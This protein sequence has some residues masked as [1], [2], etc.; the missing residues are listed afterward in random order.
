MDKNKVQITAQ[1]AAGATAVTFGSVMRIILKVL[2]TIILIGITTGLLFTCIFAYYVKTNLT[3]DLDISLDDMSLNLASTIYYTDENGE[4]QELSSVYGKENRIWVDYENIPKYMTYAA[5]A[6]EDK[7]FYNHKG[8]DW[9]RTL[10]AFTNMFVK[11]KDDFGGSTITQQLIK[12]LTKEDDITVQRKILEIFRALEFER[13]YNDKDKIMEW[14]LN[15]IYLGQSC[16]GVSTASQTYFGKNVWELDLAE[17]ASIIAITNNPS[18][19]DPFISSEN[20]RERRELILFEMYDQGYITHSEYTEALAE[21]PVFKRSEEEEPTMVIDSYYVETVIHDVTRDLAEEKGIDEDTAIRLLQNGGLQVYSC[22]D[23]KIQNIMDNVYKD[24]Q[25]FPNITNLKGEPIQ[26]AAVLLD[27]YNGEIKALVGG[28][29]EKTA[30]LILN[31]ATDS[32]RPPG[33]SIKPIA[34]YGPAVDQGLITPSTLVNDSANIRLSGTNWYPKNADSANDGIITIQRALTRS[35]NTVSAQLL[36]KLTPAVSY[37]YL[38]E[39]LGVTSLV[40]SDCDYAPLSLGQPYYGITVRE[41]AQAYDAF[42]NDGVFTYARTYTHVTDSEGNM[43]LDNS[44]KTIVAFKAN[45]AWTMCHMLNQVALYGCSNE[46][47]IG[48]MT[49]AGKT[50]SSTNY[51]DRWFVGFTPYY[52]CAVWTG[53]DTPYRMNVYGNPATRVWQKIMQPVHEGLE[54]KTFPTPT[55]GGPTNIFGDL[56]E[57]PSPSPSEDASE[58]PTNSGTETEVPS[59]TPSAPAPSQ[60][61]GTDEPLA[62]IMDFIQGIR[63][64]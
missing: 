34:T 36:D 28:V 27:P 9:Y 61:V 59:P 55:L 63:I 17:C 23:M 43:V 46:C 20:N 53:Y 18:K 26:S 29:G 3:D 31:R 40:E 8:V 5:V 54:L 38:T 39:C 4:Y 11:M 21:K 24:P 58:K 47:N 2:V 56:K 6:I 48:N 50:G 22:I 62:G 30:N 13:H 33:S 1:K 45:T 15:V 37:R 25:N 10:G 14:Y 60:P 51:Q 32:P 12:N 64:A 19:Y 52:V 44:P 57:S 49:I 41:M 42:V 35:I 16:N 7:R